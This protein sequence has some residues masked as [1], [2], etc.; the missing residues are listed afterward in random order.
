M[1]ACTRSKQAVRVHFGTSDLFVK[2]KACRHKNQFVRPWLLNTVWL[3]ICNTRRIQGLVP[4]GN[5]R[6][7]INPQCESVF[8]T[9]GYGSNNIQMRIERRPVFLL[10]QMWTNLW[11]RGK[12]KGEPK[13]L[14][15]C[16][17]ITHLRCI[18]TVCCVMAGGKAQWYTSFLCAERH[19]N[20]K[21]ASDV[22]S[23]TL[24]ALKKKE[25]KKRKSSPV[26]VL[27]FCSLWCQER[28]RLGRENISWH[29]K[30][31]EESQWR[32]KAQGS[33]RLKGDSLQAPAA[34]SVSERHIPF[35][36]QHS[37]FQRL[38]NARLIC[39]SIQIPLLVPSVWRRHSVT[40]ATAALLSEL[41]IEKRKWKDSGGEA[42]EH[43]S[44]AQT[45][46]RDAKFCPP[47]VGGQS[48]AGEAHLHAHTGSRRRTELQWKTSRRNSRRFWPEL[49]GAQWMSETSAPRRESS[50]RRNLWVP[51][52]LREFRFC[53]LQTCRRE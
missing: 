19:N 33:K 53:S 47:S 17:N 14:M 44:L 25:R 30:E 13:H 15:W 23:A 52:L 40:M 29:E 36:Q 42:H 45:F 24:V 7:Q 22:L 2:W 49:L 12:T 31:K 3:W 5:Y 9:D 20:A 34:Q 50:A 41:R 46:P 26:R 35:Y 11:V 43:S 48:R 39:S 18:H 51:F 4:L 21:H 10:I 1:C 8:P 16:P 38:L 37:N 28:E 32:I 6:E 27:L